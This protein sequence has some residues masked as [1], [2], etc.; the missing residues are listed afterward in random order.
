LKRTNTILTNNYSERNQSAIKALPSALE[1]KEPAKPHVIRAM[2][3][4][5]WKKNKEKKVEK[6]PKTSNMIVINEV[7]KSINVLL[8]D[9]VDTA[10]EGAG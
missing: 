7:R 6:E 8:D 1:A 2:D 10:K 5:N 9:H 3:A 4:A